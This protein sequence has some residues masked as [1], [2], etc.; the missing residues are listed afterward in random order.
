LLS[1]NPYKISF[2]LLGIKEI[3]S[4][5]IEGDKHISEEQINKVAEQEL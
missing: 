3:S 5:L 4:S 1:E 2:F